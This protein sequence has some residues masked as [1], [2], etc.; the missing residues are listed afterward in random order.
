M[1]NLKIKGG[2]GNQLFQYAVVRNLAIKNN[3]GINIDYSY[4]NQAG[5]DTSRQYLLDLFKVKVTDNHSANSFYEKIHLLHKV[6]R[7]MGFKTRLYAKKYY[8]ENGIGFD[9]RILELKDHIW[10]TGFFQSYK[11]FS[12][13]ADI[14]RE[15]FKLR[16]AFPVNSNIT[17][18]ESVFIHIRRGDYVSNKAASRFFACCALDYYEKAIKLMKEKLTDPKFF[19]FS[20][21]ISWVKNNLKLDG[22]VYVSDGKLQDFEELALMS[23]C[24]HAIIAN[25]SFSWWGAWLINNPSKIVIAPS[26]WF[27]SK[28]ISTKDL[29]PEDWVRI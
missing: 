13:I 27:V 2:L 11:Y 21:D 23:Q 10:L 17:E 5:P 22:A 20:D 14:L 3:V 8:F 16:A 15:E 6:L 4:Y 9:S 29:I 18:T 24:H 7:K 26:K 25:S 1:I 12:D 19:I 28:K